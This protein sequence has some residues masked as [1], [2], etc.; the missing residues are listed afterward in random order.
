MAADSVQPLAIATGLVASAGPGLGRVAVRLQID[1][2]PASALR[3]IDLL[4]P[5]LAW[6][7]SRNS[8]VEVS[9]GSFDPRGSWYVNPLPQASERLEFLL[10]PAS[11]E[12][13][14]RGMRKG[15]RLS[16]RK[17][18]RIG[19][20]ATLGDERDTASFAVLYRQTLA[21]L[22]QRKGVPRA[23]FDP[24]PL[25]DLIQAEAARL[26]IAREGSEMLAGLVFG[27]F[28][29][30]AYYLL[31][32]AGPR[33]LETGAVAFTLAYALAD[34]SKRGFQRL[35]LGG[36]SAE[37]RDPESSDHGL[38]AF[39]AGLGARPVACVSG[40]VVCRPGRSAA[41]GFARRIASAR[42]LR[43]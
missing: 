6:T 19:L 34:L 15:A 16:I 18:E 33:A 13:L 5:L 20:Q 17:A 29:D 40:R 9:L 26:Y 43:R 42:T 7:R 24:R 10:S 41:I 31:N 38:Y 36:V 30:G 28:G 12:E 22:H 2:P 27:C 14:I 39:K 23:R 21:R 4:S 1:S 25:A 35:N 8:I 3:G 32:G 11:R 37:A